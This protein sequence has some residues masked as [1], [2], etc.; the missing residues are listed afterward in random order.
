[1]FQRFAIFKGLAF[2]G[3]AVAPGFAC[4]LPVGFKLFWPLAPNP[5]SGVSARPNK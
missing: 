5:L 2:W 1:L 4:K 3:L